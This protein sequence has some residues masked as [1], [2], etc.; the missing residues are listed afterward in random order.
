MREYRITTMCLLLILAAISTAAA[1][2]PKDG[3]NFK[4]KDFV[5][6]AWF[7]PDGNDAEVRVYKE[8]GFN[9]VMVGRYMTAGGEYCQPDEVQRQLDLARKYKLK[10][11]LDTYTRNHLPWGGI[12]VPYTGP[13]HHNA[14]PPEL[15]WI[16][17]RFGKHPALIGYMIGDDQGAI[18]DQTG[19]NTD[20]LHKNAP[21]LIPWICGWVPAD[22]LAR[23]G[24]PIIDPQM[25]PTLNNSN[26]ADIQ[27]RN[28]TSGLQNLRQQCR[29]YDLISWPMFNIVGVKADSM[30]RYQVYSSLAYG[31]QGIWY[32]CY[33]DNTGEFPGDAGRAFNSV[34]EGQKGAVTY[35]AVK[36]ELRPTY[37]DAQEC[38]RR[39]KTWGPKLLGCTAA[40]IYHTGW[41]Q[42][43]EDVFIPGYGK[44]VIKMSDNLLLGILTKPNAKPL[45][46]VVDKRVSKERDAFAPREIEITFTGNVSRIAILEGK[47]TLQVKGNIVKLTLPAGGG[48][49]LELG[50]TD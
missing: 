14:T 15:E 26:P 2:S 38:N 47:Q 23:H 19:K 8:C 35:K 13:G 46:M 5:I 50:M 16:H 49:L 1:A 41:K 40:G 37:Y 29:K 7:G 36:E 34:L 31:A 33:R 48:Q 9:S 22:D 30:I 42:D 20:F 12:S 6:C 11:F 4:M 18:T 39:V 10:A 32:F 28:Y 17:K 21:H 25:Y 45:A 24:N 44:T 27:A 3:W 43:G